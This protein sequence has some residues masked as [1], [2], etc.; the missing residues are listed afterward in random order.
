MHKA[1]GLVPSITRQEEQKP[2]VILGYIV[3]SKPAWA[4]CSS[5]NEENKRGNR[6]QDIVTYPRK[7][8]VDSYADAHK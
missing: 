7:Q 3:S 8:L 5:L 1:L 6:P 4:T 2:K